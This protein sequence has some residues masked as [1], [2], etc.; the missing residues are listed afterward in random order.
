MSSD[1]TTAIFR[2]SHLST[3]EKKEFLPLL[4][5]PDGLSIAEMRKYTAERFKMYKLMARTIKKTLAT[6]KKMPTTPTRSMVVL[7]F[8][9]TPPKTEEREKRALRE[10]R[11]EWARNRKRKRQMSRK[12]PKR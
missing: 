6:K 11:N 10:K 7:D 9:M 4:E 3:E 1:V 12:G 5:R 2:V 8:L